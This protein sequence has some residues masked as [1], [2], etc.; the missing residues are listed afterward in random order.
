MTNGTTNNTSDQWFVEKLHL[1]QLGLSSTIPS[2]IGLLSNLVD[3]DL[4]KLFQLDLFEY[5]LFRINLHHHSVSL[6][7]R[8]KFPII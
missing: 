6:F 8:R 1:A 2:E 3:L 5:R 7:S 4:C